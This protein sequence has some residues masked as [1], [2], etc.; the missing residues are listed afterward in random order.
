M[1][2]D[3]ASAGQTG[4]PAQAEP[5]APALPAFLQTRAD[6]IYVDPAK[7]ATKDDFGHFVARLIHA[8]FRFAGLNYPLFQRLANE[9]AP[10][11]EAQVERL[12]AAIVPFEAAR[13]ELYK[14]VKITS[15][16]E[17]A[18]YFFEPAM[19]ATIERTPLLG[20]VDEDGTEGI[21][22]WD[23]RRDRKP[24]E[25]DPDEFVFDLWTK[26]IS[27]GIDY[28]RVK[29]IIAGKEVGRFPV[30]RMLE[31]VEGSDAG[32]REV[33]AGLHRDNAPKQLA[34][35]RLDLRQFA[36]RF[37]QIDKGVPIIKKIPRS[38]GKPGMTVS[39]KV[40]EPNEKPKDF[41]LATLAGPGTKVEKRPDGEYIVSAI[42]GFLSLDSK[43]NLVSV[44]EKVVNTEGVSLRTT[45]DLNLVGDEF[46]THGDVQERR[47]V[48]GKHMSFR[49]DVYGMIVS[50]GGNVLID[51]NIVKG[52][53]ESPGGKITVQGRASQADITAVDGEIELAVA[54]GCTIVGSRVRIGRASS[55]EIVAEHL[56][57]EQL[58]GCKVAANSLQIGAS[59]NRR[60]SETAIYVL[61]PDF[62]EFED[63]EKTLNEELAKLAAN[64]TAISAKLAEL[65][66]HPELSKFL[67]LDIKLKKGELK[68]SPEQSEQVHKAA[69]RFVPI[70]QQI[71]A[72]S[73]ELERQKAAQAAKKA[74]LEATI[75]QR[76]ETAAA[77]GCK[78][79][80]VEGESI[81][82]RL[83]MLPG[84]ATFS[85]SQL[86]SIRTRMRAPDSNR[87]FYG[88]EGTFEWRLS[89]VGMAD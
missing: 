3:N 33:F 58:E 15:G 80:Q 75:H 22:G 2:R 82:R 89:V 83:Q 55:C 51:G 18:E 63:R 31:P 41:D 7:I 71:R 64:A 73:A 34:G 68:L 39:G 17:L 1:N 44:T 59:R 76:Q 21:V 5:A 14:A 47:V 61:V 11:K 50:R 29:R 81:V 13:K 46:E 37:P 30:A 19:I 88:T 66:G 74:E 35:G 12:A 67:A 20:P 72:L 43:T 9:W 49:G 85:E 77:V 48:E 10:A 65:R 38:F 62:G 32:I 24:T 27:Y 52:K 4:V 40:V 54:E 45:G 86:E 79:D 23:E 87:L 69:L 84:E 28:D 25:L 60:D 70:I 8:G 6:G 16:G 57:A 36:N 26:G 53:A 42:D 78:I 56:E